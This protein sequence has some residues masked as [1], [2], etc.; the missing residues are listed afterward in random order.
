MA[1]APNS[2]RGIKRQ[3]PRHLGLVPAIFDA[4]AIW[5][6][7][8]TTT[9]LSGVMVFLSEHLHLPYDIHHFDTRRYY[10][11]VLAF[12]VL[13]RFVV[14]GHYSRRLPWLAQ[15]EGV[16][17][18]IGFAALFDCF[19]Y[20]FLDYASLPFWLIFN[21]ALCAA[22]ILLLRQMSN[23][24]V[25]KSPR[26]KLPVAVLGDSR[27]ILDCMHAFGT[28]SFAG[29]DIKAVLL[30]NGAGL[31]QSENIP[32]GLQSAVVYNNTS[33]FPAF[34]RDNPQYYY[35]FDMDYLRGPH[36]EPIMSAIEAA[37]IE[38]GVIPNTR[39]LDIY[40]M[41]PHYFFGNDVML[42]HRRDPIRSPSG[43]ALKRLMDIGAAGV[44]LPFLGL[45][46]L[47][48]WAGKKIQKSQSPVF[49]GGKRIGLKGA[50]FSCWKFCTMRP[51][52]DRILQD[53]LDK[54]PAAAEEWAKYQKLRNDP[55]IDSAISKFLRKTSLD[56]L[57]QLWNVFTGDMSLVGPRP[58]LPEQ[59]GDY[60]DM[61][62]QYCAVRPG[63]T[64][65]WQVSGRNET[66]FQQRV[67]WDGWYIR[68]WTLWYDIV[69]LVKTARVFL[70]G[71]G[72]Y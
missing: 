72:A 39:T 1:V 44:L 24:I 69:I 38:Y 20:Y 33:D 45:L 14:K 23:W 30:T 32:R 71:S 27:T 21:W 40:G 11:V 59:I 34:I 5:L 50:E 10:Y 53:I 6:A 18:T 3:I 15:M 70:T 66:S 37:Q 63:L 16:I 4:L 25:S 51:G 36:A 67:H 42:L 55:R 56:E 8:K 31:L 28:D 7:F 19:N 17:K 52:A 60:G 62:R 54:D 9:A 64:G 13:L 61:F 41:E 47:F 2:S 22:Y 49:Y 35:V 29:Y 12:F 46:T 57:P 26:W 58:I 43:R 68:N 65:L 48:V